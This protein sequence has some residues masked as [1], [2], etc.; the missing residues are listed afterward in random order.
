MM[1]VNDDDTQAPA[2]APRS[3]LLFPDG[4]CLGNPGPGG[5][6]VVIHE[7]NSDTIVRRHALAGSAGG[8]TTNNRMEL[9]AAIEGLR[10]LGD[11]GDPVTVVSDSEYV[12]KGMTQWLEGWKV[13]GWRKSDR[14]PV[15]N[16]DLWTVLDELAGGL[17]VS[18]Q[19]V[20]GHNCHPLNEVADMLANNAAKGPLWR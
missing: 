10:Y 1:T 14:K 4:A 13:R 12:V 3:Y 2:T 16:V 11:P 9:Q 6:G 18:W 7:L 20:R 15:L 19:W 8:D 5:W 17:R